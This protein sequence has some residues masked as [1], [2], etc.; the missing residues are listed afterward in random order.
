ML[1]HH[2]GHPSFVKV[3]DFGIARAIGG[4]GLGTMGI[5]GTIGYIRLNKQ[6]RLSQMRGQI[7]M[8]WDVW[9]WLSPGSCLLKALRIR[10]PFVLRL[11][12]RAIRSP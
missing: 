8:L 1:I 9:L 10:A 4:Q 5:L 6:A 3:I 12:S 2:V 11:I 7:S